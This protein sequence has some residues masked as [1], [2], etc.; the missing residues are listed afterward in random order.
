MIFDGFLVDNIWGFRQHFS[1]KGLLEAI[2]NPF[3]LS[4]WFDTITKS[5]SLEEC[6][7]KLIEDAKCDFDALIKNKRCLHWPKLE[8]ICTNNDELM[9]K[10][11]VWD[12]NVDPEQT[13]QYRNFS[14]LFLRFLTIGKYTMDG[15]EEEEK[16]LFNYLIE[17]GYIKTAVLQLKQISREKVGLYYGEKLVTETKCNQG[18]LQSKNL[19]FE[20]E[21]PDTGYI[22]IDKEGNLVNKSA[23][24]IQDIGKKAVKAVLNSVSYAILLEDGQV[25]HNLKYSDLP[26][27]PVKNIDLQGEQLVWQFMQ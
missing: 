25:I 18:L 23:F 21:H 9:K 27:A 13:N 14:A 4:N 20:A 6:D 15:N 1:V 19:I 3:I 16:I 22:G 17:E 24:H 11:L 2:N 12:K 8:I 26:E 7:E 10:M 5:G